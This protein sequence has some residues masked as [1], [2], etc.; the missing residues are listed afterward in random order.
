MTQGT[1]ADSN[2]ALRT[3]CNVRKGIPASH[4]QP[5]TYGGDWSERD[6]PLPDPSVLIRP[7][8]PRLMCN[9]GCGHVFNSEW[10]YAR[11]LTEHIDGTAS[12]KT[13][14]Q[15]RSLGNRPM[16]RDIAGVWHAPNP[17]EK[18]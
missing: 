4:H 11:H 18:R 3:Q 14:R 9:N 5:T 17:G 6:D 12:C 16:A 1:G 10:N 8:S 15:L 7:G 13:P 2:A